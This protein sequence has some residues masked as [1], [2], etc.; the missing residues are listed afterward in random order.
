MW[1]ARDV[2]EPTLRLTLFFF[3]SW[4]D[5][6][7]GQSRSSLTYK[8]KV[9]YPSTGR[10]TLGRGVCSLSGSF[11]QLLRRGSERGSNRLSPVVLFPDLR[12]KFRRGVLDS[13]KLCINNTHGHKIWSFRRMNFRSFD[14]Y[15][16]S[17]VKL[18]SRVLLLM[19]RLIKR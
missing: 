8:N 5:G 4:R 19:T 6:W 1:I 11:G 9:P 7:N 14:C 18:N 17:F 15:Y 3:F 16:L 13:L 12:C 10:V 2:Y